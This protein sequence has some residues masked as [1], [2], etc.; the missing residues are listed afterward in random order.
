VSFGKPD[1]LWLF[2]LVLLPGLWAVRARR[3]RA[4]S[5]R[6][7]AQRGRVPGFRSFSMLAAAVFL[8]LALAQPRFGSIISPPLPPGHD[9]VLLIDVSRSMAAEDAVP[10]RLAVAIDAAESLVS[11]LAP[12]PANRAAIVAFAGRGVIRYPLT[13]NL[14]AVIDVLHRLQPGSVRP[15]GTDLGAGL[16]AALETLGQ[17]E[18]AEGRSIVVFSDGEDLADH[19]RSRLDRLVRAGVIVHVVAIGD[20][21]QGHPV[22][23]GTGGQPLSYQGEKVLSRR[24]DAT[25]EAIARQT[26]GAV[27]KLGLASADLNALYRTR[28][29]PV[30]Q[31]KRAAARF[32]E[33][34][35]RFPLFLAGALGLALSGCWPA[36]RVGPW[37]WVWSRVAGAILL[38]GLALTGIGAGR[39]Q[40]NGSPA[41]NPEPAGTRARSSSTQPGIPPAV[42]VA[43]LVARGESAYLSGRFTEALSTFESVIERAP[44]QPVPRYNAAATLFQL[45]RYEEARQRYQEARDRAG[46]ALRTKIDYALGNTALVLGDVAGA[47]EQYDRCLASTAVGVG[48]DTVRQDAAINRQFALEQAPPSI[49]PQGET[50]RDQPPSRK[51]NRPPGARKRGDGGSEPTPDDPSG[52]GPEPDGSNPQ[53]ATDN[54]PATGRRRAGGAGGASKV[55]PGSPGESPDDRLDNALDQIRDAQRRRLPEESP[56]EPSGDGRKDW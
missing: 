32:A 7:L 54:R 26:E 46:T 36:G 17:E 5:W 29:A 22:P 13:E 31:R 50:D 39:V 2:L 25:L 45:R 56:A 48:L 24:V 55:P 6:E 53:G 42:P 40:E 14:G 51:R 28:I 21:E 43:A 33:R 11:A 10:S 44:G 23:S 16:D 18:H 20:P 9:V 38:G 19:W 3:L 41:R 27:L 4:R 12:D 52:T 37:R 1:F 34:A 8:I 47:V 35:E 30:A 49:A 15:G